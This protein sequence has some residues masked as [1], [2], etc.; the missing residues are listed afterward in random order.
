ML[1]IILRF[2]GSLENKDKKEIFSSFIFS[3]AASLSEFFSLASI[4]PILTALISKNNASAPVADNSSFLRSFSSFVEGLS[5]LNL[6]VSFILLVLVSCCLRFLANRSLVYTS[7]RISTRLARRLISTFLYSPYQLRKQDSSS[8][9][10]TAVTSEIQ[11][12]NSIIS[13]SLQICANLLIA[14]SITI[15]ML[16]IDSRLIIIVSLILGIFYLLV[17]SMASNKLNKLSR[18]FAQHANLQIKEVQQI[19]NMAD[20]Y[21]CTHTQEHAI[22]AY[23]SVDS[24]MRNAN[25]KIII[26]S[27]L[28][29]YALELIAVICIFGSIIFKIQSGA[30]DESYLLGLGALAVGIQK[31]LPSLQ[32]IYASWSRIK[33][34]KESVNNMLIRMDKVIHVPQLSSNSNSTFNSIEC[35][36]MKIG[37]TNNPLPYVFNLKINKGCY[38]KIIGES[39]SGKSTFLRTVA[40]LQ[41]PLEG[42]VKIKSETHCVD[43]TNY[44][45]NTMA[46]I[47]QDTYL[48][49]Q[50]VLDNILLDLPKSDFNINK[51]VA[52]LIVCKLEHLSSANSDGLYKRVGE[53]G[54]LISG[55]QKQR[56]N[57]ARCLMRD[58]QLLLLDESFS[59]LNIELEEQIK[60]NIIKRFP[61]ITI[62]EVTHRRLVHQS[63]PSSTID[64]SCSERWIDNLEYNYTS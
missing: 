22:K 7:E 18:R 64:L 10:V 55:G 34:A 1:S 61:S 29:R 39:G 59:A 56:I 4:V 48:L 20:F 52:L 51:A 27:I 14:I 47:G 36:K 28:P 17:A 45:V 60:A 9:L 11:L 32:T 49:D 43:E 5:D 31:L 35:N 3:L 50:T 2:F 41:P 8:K 63:A 6:I 38:L 58:P 62:L 13:H 23:T 30:L 19:A 16:L 12:A 25:A 53:N 24:A 46:Y 44:L 33:G 54:S 57:I 15:A 42:F 26:L 21:R 37:N 40:G